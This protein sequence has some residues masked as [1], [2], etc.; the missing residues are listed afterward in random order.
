MRIALS[1]T[2]LCSGLLACRAS[3]QADANASLGGETDADLAAELENERAAETDAPAR[4]S[5]AGFSSGRPLLGAR[6]DLAVVPEKTTMQCSC[7]KVALGPATAD[8]FQWSAEPPAIDPDTQL[9][10]AMTSDGT[11]CQHPKGSRGASYWGYRRKGDDIVVY[12][13]SALE[14]PPLTSGAIIPKPFGAGQVLVAPAEAKLPYGRAREGKGV[15]P[16]G[17]PGNPRQTP[18]TADEMGAPAEPGSG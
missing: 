4:L 11:D 16:L 10:F 6:H 18:V 3:V 1:L 17:N 8:T 9:V 14:G 15:C 13:E 7:L 12:I 2:A 5:A